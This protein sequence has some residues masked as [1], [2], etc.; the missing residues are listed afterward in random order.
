MIKEIADKYVYNTYN[1]KNVVFVKGEGSKWIDENGETYIDFGSGIGI[2]SL[3]IN[4]NKWKKAIIKQINQISHTS[5][6]YYNIPSTLLAEKLCNLTGYKKVFFAN[7]G[8]EANECAIKTARKYSYDKYGE[9]RNEIISLTNSFHGRTIATLSLTGQDVFHQDFM[10]FLSGFKY[11]DIND[12]SMLRKNISKRTC[13]IY[14]ELIQGEGGVNV[15]DF[16]YVQEIRKICDSQDIL[17]I[18]D[19]VQTGN[20]RTGKLY[21]YQHYNIIPD[22]LTTAKGLGNGLPISCAMFN[23]KSMNVL[24]PGS[25]GCTFG[26]NPI[27]CAGSIAFLEQLTPKFLERIN[28]KGEYIKNKISKINGVVRVTGLGLMLGVEI[29][30]DLNKIIDSC[31]KNKL[32][33]LAAKG[34]IRL[35]PSLNITYKEIDKGI[36]LLEKSIKEIQKNK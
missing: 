1:K 12:I 14:L 23:E 8:A 4:N 24:T 10:P 28:Q 26:G 19:E 3:G 16:D 29:N 13:A 25:H 36:Q 2:N 32:L 30:L 31:F 35:L 11:V 6:L 17:M 34:K 21:A 9:D 20:G 5:N 7:S 27:I 18:V 33:V 22:I 15:L